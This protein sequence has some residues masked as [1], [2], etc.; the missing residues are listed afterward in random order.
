MTEKMGAFIVSTGL[1]L[2]IALHPALGERMKQ[3][4]S[5]PGENDEEYRKNEDGTVCAE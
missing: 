2:K 5:N 3:L 1:R 4:N